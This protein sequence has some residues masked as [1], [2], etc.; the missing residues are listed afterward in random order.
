MEM[1]MLLI[2]SSDINSFIVYNICGSR[3]FSRVQTVCWLIYDCNSFHLKHAKKPI[4]NG[5]IMRQ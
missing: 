3:S 5:S 4:K 2:L 1:S